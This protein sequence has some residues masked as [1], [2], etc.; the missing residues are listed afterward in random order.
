MPHQRPSLFLRVLSWLI[1]AYARFTYLTSRWQVEGFDELK[2]KLQKGDAVILAFWHGRSAMMPNFA[3]RPEN[4]YVI[5]SRHRDG[6]FMAHIVS[7]FGLQVIRGSTN[8]ANTDKKGA[9]DRGG[10]SALRGALAVLMSDKSLCLTP[11]GP[12]GPRMRV[13]GS[14]AEVAAHTGK[15]IYPITFST[16]C[17]KNIGSWDRYLLPYPFGRAV[18]VCGKPVKI[19]RD[20]TPVELKKAR[21]TIENRLNQITA[22][23][24]KI[25]GRIPILPAP[26]LPKET[27]RKGK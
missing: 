19:S 3:P 25:A 4:V 17:G 15:E 2:A 8:R 24:D 11:D 23:A 20:A 7:H 13:S 1:Y 14:I 12:K 9:K 6:E 18:F 21:K 22:H 10:A 26:L 27:A 5:T 16:T